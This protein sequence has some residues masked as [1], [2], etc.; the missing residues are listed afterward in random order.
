LRNTERKLHL[1]CFNHPVD[2]WHNTDITPHNWLS[3]IPG[4]PLLCKYVGLISEVRLAEHRAGIY[5]KVHYLDVTNQFPYSDNS[6]E[7]AF[8]SHVLEHIDRRFVPHLFAEVFRVLEPSGIFRVAV[9]SLELAIK[10]YQPNA[11]DA[12]LNMIFESNHR[13]SKNTH[14]WMYSEE[15]LT[16]IFRESGFVACGPQRYKSGRLPNLEAIDNR[17]E[18]SIYVEGEKPQSVTCS[19]SWLHPS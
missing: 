4:A 10:S 15:S 1:G 17:P 14:K 12:C 19:R 8:C 7:G 11:P 13:S 2:G 5:R 9:P 18:N 16:R 3:K 6:F